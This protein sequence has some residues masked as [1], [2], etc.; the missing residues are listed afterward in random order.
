MGFGPL[1][2]ANKA[3]IVGVPHSV[4]VPEA[5]PGT[6]SEGFLTSGVLMAKTDPEGVVPCFNC[7]SGPDIETLL[8]GVPINAIPS[9]SS[10]TI[11]VLGD[12]LFYGGNA[13]FSYSIKANP[14]V[15]PVSSG[16]VVGDVSP[17]SWFAEFPITAPAHGMYVLTGTISVGETQGQS[18]SVSSTIIIGAA[19]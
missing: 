9:G 5:T 19:N 16:S 11:V 8:L 10:V 4:T 13:T 17:G 7:V 12:D 14:T 1:S 3:T 15:A 6:V 18:S 2:A